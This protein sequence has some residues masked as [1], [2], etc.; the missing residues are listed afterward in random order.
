MTAWVIPGSMSLSPFIYIL[1]CFSGEPDMYNE[2]GILH[3][4]AR[5][6]K[7]FITGIGKKERTH[8]KSGWEDG[9]STRGWP[10]AVYL[11]VGMG[12]QS[13]NR[14]RAQKEKRRKDKYTS[15]MVEVGSIFHL[16]MEALSSLA[17]GLRA[18]LNPLSLV[19]S[20]HT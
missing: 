1:F 12:H 2:L 16:I 7:I 19:C 14:T 5:T 18:Q 3:R 17:Q 11:Q 15:L 6:S 4:S 13:M 8:G 10:D 20:S 9:M